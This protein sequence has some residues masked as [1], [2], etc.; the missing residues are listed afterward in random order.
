[1]GLTCVGDGR[2][3]G[4][5]SL[6]F[7]GIVGDVGAVADERRDIT[8]SRKAVPHVHG[9]AQ[10]PVV[11]RSAQSQFAQNAARFGVW[12]VVIHHDFQQA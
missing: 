6:P 8:H 12:P 2:V 3:I 10:Q 1:M 5:Q 11:F 4:G 9:D 7:G